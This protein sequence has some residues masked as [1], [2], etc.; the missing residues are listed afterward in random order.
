MKK[1]LLLLLPLLLLL[2][3]SHIKSAG[4]SVGHA[5]KTAAHAVGEGAKEVTTKIGHTSRDAVHAVE[6]KVSE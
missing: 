3:C 1:V 2:G 6:K 4:R 5:S